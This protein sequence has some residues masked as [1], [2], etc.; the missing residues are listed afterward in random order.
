MRLPT[1]RSFEFV[2]ANAACFGGKIVYDLHFFP[3]FALH[4]LARMAQTPTLA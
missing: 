1:N 4:S 2:Q 3:F